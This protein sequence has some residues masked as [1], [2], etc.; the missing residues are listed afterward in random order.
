MPR[1]GKRLGPDL[2]GSFFLLLIIP[3]IFIKLLIRMTLA[4]S[5]LL[6]NI[7]RMADNFAKRAQ[8][9]SAGIFWESIH[10]TCYFLAPMSWLLLMIST[11]FVHD[12]ILIPKYAWD[13]LWHPDG[14][15]IFQMLCN[16]NGDGP[17]KKRY[18][19]RGLACQDDNLV[20]K[21][22]WK[23]GTYHRR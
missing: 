3:I 20:T 6:Y 2:G 23:V 5:T 9:I 4:S 1:L 8:E 11:Q 17:L 10:W 16:P 21:W 13:L 22:T 18:Y 12:I 19:S 14:R 7:M 15:S